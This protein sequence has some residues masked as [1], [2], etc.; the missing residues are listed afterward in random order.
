MLGEPPPEERAVRVVDSLGAEEV[1]WVEM[2]GVV[3][4]EGSPRIP[5]P[6]HGEEVISWATYDDGSIEVNGRAVGQDLTGMSP[7]QR[8]KFLD[9]RRGELEIIVVRDVSEVS[10]RLV[11][12]LDGLAGDDLALTLSGCMAGGIDLGQLGRLGPK[13]VSLDLDPTC[14]FEIG[15]EIDL[16]AMPS[17]PRLRA[18]GVSVDSWELHA[19]LRGLERLRT[20]PRLS[21][22]LLS[23]IEVDDAELAQV[24]GISRLRALTLSRIPVGDAGLAPLRGLSRLRALSLN[25][26]RV[27]PADLAHLGALPQLEELILSRTHVGDAGVAR[28]GGLSRLRVLRLDGTGVSDAGLAPLAGLSRLTEL[29]LVGSQVGDAGLAH[30]SGLTRLEWLDLGNTAV[31]SAGLAH[32]RGLSE[33]R[34]LGLRLTLVGDGGLAHLRGL[35]RLQWLD[36]SGTQVTDAGLARL[37]GLSGLRG[38]VVGPWSVTDAGIE[39][40]RRRHPRCVV[41]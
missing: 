21:G 18:L 22:L 5:I 26:T 37:R 33:L 17:L 12:L 32:L 19:T 16:R 38:V 2:G 20:L 31:T 25:G 1:R 35:S 24:G 27:R 7:L 4:V 34:G 6:F 13:L 9:R 36:L 10:S 14:D 30:L 28:L 39:A 3:F 8:R 11:D 29:N 23:N 40:F 41:E 15:I